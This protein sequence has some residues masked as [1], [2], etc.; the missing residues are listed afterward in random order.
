[1][2]FYSLLWPSRKPKFNLSWASFFQG[3]D[4]NCSINDDPFASI[5]SCDQ[6]LL[7]L[8]SMTSLNAKPIFD[9]LIPVGFKPRSFESLVRSSTTWT[10]N[11]TRTSVGFSNVRS[12]AKAIS[13]LSF[14]NWR[15]K[16]TSSGKQRG[17]SDPLRLSG[18]IDRTFKSDLFW[19]FFDEWWHRLF[20][21]S[22]F[23]C[24]CLFPIEK[25]KRKVDRFS[26]KS[27]S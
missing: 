14:Y 17:L 21:C 20:G 19:S 1:M 18:R 8:M 2:N 6:N 9:W 4:H 26:K 27:A 3:S 22:V 12:M 25:Q 5:L 7:I 11:I 24:R 10:T 13:K 23:R 16:W 15:C